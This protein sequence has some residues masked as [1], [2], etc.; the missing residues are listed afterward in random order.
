MKILFINTLHDYLAV[1]LIYIHTVDLH[2]QHVNQEVI[3]T[4]TEYSVRLSW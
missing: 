3:F 4:Q 1:S 2:F